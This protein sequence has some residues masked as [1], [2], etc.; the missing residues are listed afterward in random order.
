MLSK[1]T[2]SQ[3]SLA[4]IGAG[5]QGGGVPRQSWHSPEAFRSSYRSSVAPGNREVLKNVLQ[6]DQKS[7]ETSRTWFPGSVLDQK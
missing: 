1:S 4:V 2:E 7:P 5:R 6:P 3:V